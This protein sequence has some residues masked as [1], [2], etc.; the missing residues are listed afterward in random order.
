MKFASLSEIRK[1]LQ[2]LPPKRLQ[3]LCLRIARYKKENKEL[4]AFL[5]FEDD[6]SNPDGDGNDLPLAPRFTWSG[7][8]E[9]RAVW[10]SHQP[11][12]MI[13]VMGAEVVPGM[14]PASTS[15]RSSTSSTRATSPSTGRSG[16]PARRP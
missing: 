2:M 14:R 3:E 15:S 5:L 7:A 8:L 12:S 9:A 11:S 4:L 13:T 6:N 16:P 1:E 10:R